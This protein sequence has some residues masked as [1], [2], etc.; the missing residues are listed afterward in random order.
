MTPEQMDLLVEAHISAEN[1]NDLDA[2]VAVYTEDVEHDMVG[3]PDG[4]TYGPEAAR[5]RYA[6]LAAEM[7][8]EHMTPT[9]T[10]YATDACVVE[11]LW[12]GRVPGR[13]A[14]IEGNDRRISFRML[15]IF[16]FR[17]DRISR[18]NVWIDTATIIAQLAEQAA[19]PGDSSTPARG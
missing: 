12:T 15:H 17:D 1:E 16:E 19:S 11:H 6:Q 5:W 3:A 10:Y 8:T 4:P 14:G 13:F 2:A 9:R 7:V 18:E